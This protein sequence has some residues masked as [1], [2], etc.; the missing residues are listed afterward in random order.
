MADANP[1]SSAEYNRVA[2][3][4]K[5][6]PVVALKNNDVIKNMEFL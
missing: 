6:N 5:I 4:Q 3:T 2:I 1:T